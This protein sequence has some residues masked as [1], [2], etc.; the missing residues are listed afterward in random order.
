MRT[1]KGTN[2][3]TSIVDVSLNVSIKTHPL[4]NNRT[5]FMRRLSKYVYS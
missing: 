3:Y 1:K 5:K 2:A 4:E